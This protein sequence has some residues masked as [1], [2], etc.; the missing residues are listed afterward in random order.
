MNEVTIIFLDSSQL[1]ERFSPVMTAAQHGN[2]WGSETEAAHTLN[3]ATPSS[4]MNM[5]PDCLP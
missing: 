4:R 3:A 2:G 5:L 1:A